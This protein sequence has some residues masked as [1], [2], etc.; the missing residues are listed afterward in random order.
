[1]KK[2]IVFIML[3]VCVSQFTLQAQ[4]QNQ[5]K[6]LYESKIHQFTNMRN[7]G[8]GL[9]IGGA[10]LTIV[11]ISSMS[12]AIAADPDLAT[13]A[14]VSKFTTG[15]WVTMLGVTAAGG[16]ITLWAIGGSKIRS[17]TKKL[18]SV[19][20]NLNPSPYHLVSLAYRF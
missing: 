9:T 4:D 2:A 7:A 11:G 18:N 15:Y 12:N 8:V 6:Y 3:C 13:D 10:I 17:Y 19:S 20:L 14:G 1:M 16:G 5:R